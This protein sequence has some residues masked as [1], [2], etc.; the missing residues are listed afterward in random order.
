MTAAAQA[1][2]IAWLKSGAPFGAPPKVIETHAA[3]VFLAKDRAFKLKKAV[4]LGYLD[5]STP[6]KRRDALERELTLNRRTAP[7]IYLRVVPVARVEGALALDAQGEPVDCLLEMKRFAEGALL[8]ERANAGTLDA[9]LV[10]ALA[11]RIAAFHAAAETVGVFA[12][13]AA[14]R[15]IADENARDLRSQTPSIFDADALDAY[16]AARDADFARCA[17]TLARQSSVVRRCH[18]DLHLANVFVE[19]GEP[20]LFDCIEFSDFY[21][22]MPPLYDLAFLLMDLCG[23]GLRPLANR[24]MNAW[25]VAQDPEEWQSALESFAALPLYLALRAE[26]RAKAEG[27]KPGGRTE[28][29]RY[30]HLAAAM[31]ETAPPRLI[32]IGGLSGTGKSTLARALAPDVGRPLGAVHLRTDVIRKRLAGVPHDERLPPEA[33]TREASAEVYATMERLAAAALRAGQTVIADAVF[34]TPLERASVQRIAAANDAPFHGLWLEAPAATLEARVAARKGDASD[35]DAAVL[36]KQLG[37]D[38]GAIAWA[39]LD[40]GM[41]AT[42]VAAAARKLIG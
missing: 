29:R 30:L 18:G 20:V 11:R 31:L 35:A 28:A 9:A 8:S 34:V 40:A 13:P 19:G 39:R 22:T 1:G 6:A 16:L 21:A 17:A 24:A 37:Y 33:Y 3:I 15:R 7:Q 42:A 32:A 5:F 14:A 12:W 41:G 2:V 36:R 4:D 38:V 26:V 10:E 27:R 23:R 25:L